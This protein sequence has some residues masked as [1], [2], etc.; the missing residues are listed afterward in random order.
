MSKGGHRSV[1]SPSTEF[2]NGLLQICKLQY[3]YLHHNH[4]T[5]KSY[6]RNF[7]YYPII[8]YWTNTLLVLIDI[9]KCFPSTFNKWR[10]RIQ[11][12][13]KDLNNKKMIPTCNFKIKYSYV[14]ETDYETFIIFFGVFQKTYECFHHT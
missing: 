8:M 10:Y 9:H 1:L 3:Y 5:I 13:P 6:R 11:V 2:F 14:N 12:L 7:E 4:F